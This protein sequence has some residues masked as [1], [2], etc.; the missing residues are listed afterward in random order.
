MP[1]TNP[2][3]ST[4]SA[5][6]ST[7][8]P[9]PSP[10]STPSPAGAWA[11]GERLL[12]QLDPA[13]SRYDI[14]RLRIFNHATRRYIDGIIASPLPAASA[15]EI[16][17]LP[18]TLPPQIDL[19]LATC[20]YDPASTPVSLAATLTA[21]AA[22]PG[23]TVSLGDIRDG[24]WNFD[25]SRFTTLAGDE[26]VRTSLELRSTPPGS[27]RRY[28]VA[29][30]SKDG[31]KYLS[32]FFLQFLD[33]GTGR[34]L[35]FPFGLSQIDHFE[36]RPDSRH[37]PF[38]F[39][40]VPLPAVTAAA[41]P[42]DLPVPTVI[43]ATGPQTDL[44]SGVTMELAAIAHHPANDQWWD[45]NG[46]P[47]DGPRGKPNG[48]FTIDKDKILCELFA[49]AFGPT[50]SYEINWNFTPGSGWA[51]SGDGKTSRVTVGLPRDG[52]ST[53][54]LGVS[55]PWH[56]LED[57]PL[58]TL[59]ANAHKWPITVTSIRQQGPDLLLY[60][61]MLPP[62]DNVRYHLID[63]AGKPRTITGY[64]SRN[65]ENIPPWGASTAQFTFKDLSLPDARALR[66]ETSQYEF[67]EFKNIPI[68]PR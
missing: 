66:L 52:H 14:D 9:S 16:R 64:A 34:I 47:T 61:N 22:L 1:A 55:G 62:R 68:N 59:P 36:L 49:R 42:D 27:N 53:V 4:T 10:K 7:P 15:I 20:S 38:Y 11:F 2:S 56:T 19:W 57:I 58:D 31:R 6:L 12:I 46:D 50:H 37:P 40:G 32:D 17:T 26:G 29:A 54:R 18:G 23:T 24:S 13:P 43:P 35:D 30:V 25:G 28:Q 63:A 45:I 48:S 3:P 21:T 41:A 60:I 51:A 8:P 67:A 39:D 5:I 44:P 33:G 65:E